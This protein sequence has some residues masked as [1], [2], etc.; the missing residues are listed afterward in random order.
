MNPCCLEVIALLSVPLVPSVF[1]TLC[2]MRKE[3]VTAE[4]HSSWVDGLNASKLQSVQELR[5]PLVGG[6]PTSNESN[7]H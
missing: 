2:L 5:F 4:I 1:L 3:S 7:V 6:A